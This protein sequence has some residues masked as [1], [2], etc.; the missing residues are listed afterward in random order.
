MKL[1]D[2]TFEYYPLVNR[3]TYV[4]RFANVTHDELR[5]VSTIQIH[6]LYD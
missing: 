6:I 5:D 4:S 2:P 3:A 1:S